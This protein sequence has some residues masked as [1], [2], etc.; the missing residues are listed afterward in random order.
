MGLLNSVFLSVEHVAVA[1]LIVGVGYLAVLRRSADVDLD[2]GS[3][4][5]FGDA[6]Q[7][8]YECH[9]VV[10]VESGLQCSFDHEIAAGV[11]VTVLFC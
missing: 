3:V 5:H 1:G 4:G 11:P 6:V 9:V 10:V 2:V 8:V 7:L